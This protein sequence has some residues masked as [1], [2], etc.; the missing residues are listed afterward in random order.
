MLQH[1]QFVQSAAPAAGRQ[2]MR[3]SSLPTWH[4]VGGFQFC[5]AAGLLY[6]RMGT[7]LPTDLQDR[8]SGLFYGLAVVMFTPRCGSALVVGFQS[9]PDAQQVATDD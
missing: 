8:V 9:G 3:K 5:C 4:D 7:K 1:M 6:L 2:T